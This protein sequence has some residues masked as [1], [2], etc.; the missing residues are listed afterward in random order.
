MGSI[1]VALLL[2]HLTI[3]QL[4]IVSLV[5]G[6]LFTFFNL[7]ETACLPHVVA[8]EQLPGAVAQ[9]M[10]ID[11]TSGLIGPSIGGAFYSIGRAIPFLADAISYGISVLSLFFIKV[12]FQEERVHTPVR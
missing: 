8:K 10:V 11:S 3:V 1:P 12:K 7:A 2:G 5:E 6:T 4:Y 9:Y